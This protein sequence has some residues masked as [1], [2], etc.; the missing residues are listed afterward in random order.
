MGLIGGRKRSLRGVSVTAGLGARGFPCC[1]SCQ[2]RLGV[3]LGDRVDFSVAVM[4]EC[5]VFCVSQPF[6]LWRWSA[7]CFESDRFLLLK[8]VSVAIERFKLS[9]VIC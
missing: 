9:R 5:C 3:R 4:Q 1:G 6:R 7:V 2:P 8:T